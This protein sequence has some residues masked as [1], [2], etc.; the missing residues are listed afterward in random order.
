MTLPSCDDFGIT[1]SLVDLNN[2]PIDPDLYTIFQGE[3]PFVRV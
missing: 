2:D 1:Y 3:P